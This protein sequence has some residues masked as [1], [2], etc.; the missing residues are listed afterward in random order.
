MSQ[1]GSSQWEEEDRSVGG[2]VELEPHRSPPDVAGAASSSGRIHK[3]FKIKIFSIHP[4]NNFW[5]WIVQGR[6]KKMGDKFGE[7]GS[8]RASAALSYWV[9]RRRGIQTGDISF[10]RACRSNHTSIVRTV[11]NKKFKSHNPSQ[12]VPILI[13]SPP[14]HQI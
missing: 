2:E 14:T 11:V 1:S 12:I 9:V 7:G 10:A 3:I 6:A 8:I 4:I 5:Q 13:E